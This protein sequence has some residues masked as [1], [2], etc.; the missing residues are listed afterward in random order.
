MAKKKENKYIGYLVLSIIPLIGVVWAVG[1]G[2]IHNKYVKEAQ[3]A[4]EEFEAHF[5]DEL[6]KLDASTIDVLDEVPTI[7]GDV[8]ITH[9]KVTSH[10]SHFDRDKVNAGSSYSVEIGAN[11]Y[12]VLVD[13]PATGNSNTNKNDGSISNSE[14]SNNS[15]NS[16]VSVGN[17]ENS[18]N[19]SNS[20]SN[21]TKKEVI[22]YDLTFQFF[23]TQAEYEDLCNS[24]DTNSINAQGVKDYLYQTYHEHNPKNSP[25]YKLRGVFDKHKTDINYYGYDKK[26]YCGISYDE[27]I[28][29]ITNLGDITYESKTELDKIA[30]AIDELKLKNKDDTDAAVKEKI[31]NYAVYEEALIIYKARV[32]EH[33]ILEG[34][35]SPENVQYNDSHNITTQRTEFNNLTEKQKEIISPEVEKKLILCEK[36][37]DVAWINHY[38]YNASKSINKVLEDGKVEKDEKKTV[39]NVV[40]RYNDMSYEYQIKIDEETMTIITNAVNAYNDAFP[41]SPLALKTKQADS[42]Q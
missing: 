17:S 4:E 19:T 31:P 12:T 35:P 18:N 5:K 27:V 24:Y 11:P 41:D 10:G 32:V 6:N 20:E 13:V 3:V 40:N 37:Y 28:N 39:E 30:A 29:M 42:E 23:I 2:V 15:S 16:E 34:L 8:N 33:D 26:V 14:N 7:V 22:K 36:W 1:K 9:A 38:V 25:V 21:V